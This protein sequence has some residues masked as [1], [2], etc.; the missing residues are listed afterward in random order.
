MKTKI[1]L[2][3]LQRVSLRFKRR[4]YRVGLIS[5]GIVATVIMAFNFW[6]IDH[7]ESALEDIVA[8]QSNGK[9]KLKVEKFQF[10]WLNN[11]I[12]LTNAVL[13]TTD[14]TA[15]T[16]T[17]LST[18]LIVI[19]ARGF[20]P[21]LFSKQILID[22]IQILDP[23]VIVTRINQ[24]VAVQKTDSLNVT[25]TSKFSV[26]RE[27]GKVVNSINDAIQ[28]LKINSFVLDNGSFS[29]IDKTAKNDIPFV[30]NNISIKLNNLQ[31]NESVGKKIHQ[32]ISFTDDIAIR[33][34]N[35]DMVFPGGR[36][37]LSF[38]DFRF[39]LRDK[40][41]EFD[42]CTVR[43]IK[44]DS[45]KTS[46]RIFFDKLALTNINFDT[47]YAA[48]V[49]QADSVF[50]A[51]P[52]IF[53]D[54]DGDVQAA[55]DRKKNQNID[56][57]VQQL[58]GDVMLNY[59][60]VN[61]A[62]INI[63]TIKNG[64]AN[65]FSSVNNNFELQGLMIRQNY[66]R[67]VRVERLLMTMH[68]YETK[69]QDGR[70][71]IAFDSVKFEDDAITL[72]DFA[73]KEYGAGG[74]VNNLKMPRFEVRGLSWESLLY[75]NVFEARSA[76]FYNPDIIFTAAQ[77]RAARPKSVFETLGEIGDILNLTDLGI[78]NG[79]IV[80]NLGK[81]AT[82]EL[83]N[84]NLSLFADELTSSKKIKNIQHSVNHLYVTKGIF[85]K[86]LTSATLTDIALSESKNGI[87]A[88][89][90]LLKDAGIDA[91][92]K[93]IRL[94]DII[95]DSVD[96]TI[97]IDGLSWGSGSVVI[98][99]KPKAKT[100]KRTGANNLALVNITGGPTGFRMNQGDTKISAFL[101]SV[102]VSEIFKPAKGELQINGLRVTGHDALMASPGQRVA[103]AKLSV[104]DKDNSVITGLS[105]FK[106]DE[107]DSIRIIIPQLTIIP[108]IT[109]IA[110]GNV[111]FRNLILT[112]PVI[113]AR[114]GRKDSATLAKQ[115][116]MPHITIGAALLQRPEINLTLFNKNNQPSYVTWHGIKENSYIRLTDFESNDEKP[117][118]AK[119]VDILLTNFAYIN[120]A[121]KKT[122]TNDNKL[123]LQFDNLLVQKNDSDHLEWKT[124]AS[125]LSLDKLYFDSLGKKNAV[126][127][128][129]KGDVRNI[130][131]NSK[132]M[133]SATEILQNS[134]NLKLTGTNG[135]FTSALNKINWHNLS[136][137][138]GYFSADSFSLRPL[139]SIDDYKIKKAFD[140]DYLLVKGG[141]ITGG[142][143]DLVK[144]GTD[145]ILS[146]GGIE[147]NNI[148]LLA[149][150]DRRQE[151]TALKIKPLP[152]T[153][154]LK[155][156]SKIDIDSVRIKNM[157]V[158]YHEIN[159]KTDT[160]AIVP[161][162]DLNVWMRNI[163]NH[164]LQ[165]N[166]SL[167]ILLTANVINELYTR[168]E[169]QESY[170][171]SLGTFLMKLHTGPMDLKKFNKVLLPLEAIE[172]LSGSLDSLRLEAVGNN[173]YSTGQMRMYYTGLRLRL[174]NKDD[175]QK[176]G[177]ANKLLSW[178]ANTFI[179]RKNNRGKE[180]A[181]FFVRLKNKSAINFLIKTSLSGIKSS[182]G[183]PGVKGKQRRYLRNMEKEKRY[184]QPQ[185]L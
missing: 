126:L 160:L 25:V 170:M 144:L 93:N 59:V 104:S 92:V 83:Q 185:M 130:T 23:K 129:D 63:S 21:L 116:S 50:S 22:S 47:L 105:F 27:L 123:N 164:N 151:D 184:Q 38:K 98:D 138:E 73:F 162:S 75:D 183:L 72:N 118:D 3:D 19:K 79:N 65:T 18:R 107:F 44:G 80:L 74:L 103:I 88:S 148:R 55:S 175:S 133:G 2:K 94:N 101:S 121:G 179:V 127:Q 37:F 143:L 11:R 182:V 24:A 12:R 113:N 176:Q 140:Q 154:I 139:Q 61:N 1:R 181:A 134:N 91:R 163:K 86:G 168:L 46:F 169:M 4:Q 10:N 8:S 159:P 114:L 110:G 82:L 120:A 124:N 9:I 132:F 146:I 51:N 41:V 32:E 13:Y 43:G 57:L 40:R 56:E 33:S 157:Y 5:L 109:Q 17:Q 150:N 100:Y 60:V 180:S 6:F 77:K 166:D 20:L 64:K 7:S 156:P 34:T 167:Y 178:V 48:E 31:V 29:L 136:F 149:F 115:K 102:S 15:P 58:L 42:S 97:S 89:T 142:P 36:H 90:L 141:L 14:S 84:T 153:Q 70:Y 106:A 172:V 49:I 177:F 135:V 81:G 137:T 112:D 16:L 39:S 173:N 71:S 128:L 171:D 66:E 161:V 67:P 96:Q 26:A 122:A 95:L 117:I 62:D 152:V 158:E 147:A 87:R 68:H 125:I 76:Y 30:V 52:D 28:A 174:M 35:Q 145:S 85:K 99:T 54:I 155:I 45:S 78:Q 131:L 111:F 108:D 69:L 119:Q 53:L 165:E